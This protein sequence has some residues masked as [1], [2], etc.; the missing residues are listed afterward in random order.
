M[1]AMLLR[2]LRP[3]MQSHWMPQLCLAAAAL[4][5]IGSM[6]STAGGEPPRAMI[7]VE[8]PSGTVEGQPLWW[9]EEQVKLLGR[10]GRLLSFPATEAESFAQS[11][12]RLVGYS[13]SEL[14]SRLHA[15]F[16]RNFDVTT[17]P[18]YLVVHPRGTR[19]VWAERFEQLY[20]SFYHYFQVRGMQ[21][22]EPVFPLV[23]V[24][25]PSQD[26]YLRHAAEI[27]EP[28]SPGYLGHYSARTNRIYLF[29]SATAAGSQTAATVLHEAA[30][31]AA[32]N[33]GVHRRF[34]GTPRW[35]A[36]GLALMFEA[37][38]VHRPTSAS[39]QRD[40]L[41][42]SR[43]ADFRVYLARRGERSLAEMIADDG[44]FKRDPAG[45]Y[46]QAWA[47]SFYLSETRPRE[48][49]DYLAR[50]A[51]R[52]D[53]QRAL[54]QQ[55]LADF[56]AIFGSDVALLDAQFLRYVERLR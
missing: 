44:I 34:N 5:L 33:T 4:L 11:A 51:A 55:R 42:R 35:L 14:R 37:P 52:A 7:R 3:M 2:S 47:L 20:R 17:T 31:Q 6:C 56:T 26:A 30:H 15:E 27:G 41:L 21:L 39:T 1:M 48:Y 9:S 13:A 24:V 22:R 12:P 18:H 25:F 53:F 54:P 16:G 38:G 32:F 10:D 46:A 49:T 43:L 29:D 40:R 19:S 45:A 28:V 36:E 50:T 8:L 23:A